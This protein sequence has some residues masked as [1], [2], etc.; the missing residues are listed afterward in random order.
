MGQIY[1][2]PLLIFQFAYVFNCKFC[3]GNCLKQLTDVYNFYLR[4]PA[5]PPPKKK[6][7]PKRNP[8]S[9]Q[10]PAFGKA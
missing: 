6:S 4:E 7:T 9:Y 3:T 5:P 1:V 2:N 8:K 10:P